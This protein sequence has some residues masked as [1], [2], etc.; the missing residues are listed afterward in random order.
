MADRKKCLE[1]K[2]FWTAAAQSRVAAFGKIEG[3]PMIARDRIFHVS[4]Y[5][6]T[7]YGI[8]N[9]GLI[10]TAGGEVAPL[11]C[12]K[13]AGKAVLVPSETVP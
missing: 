6:E 12:I 5:M 9:F 8:S 1:I 7:P 2:R 3:H 4:K 10:Q 13:S 11:T